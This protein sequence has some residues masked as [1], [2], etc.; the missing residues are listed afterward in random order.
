MRDFRTTLSV[1]AVGDAF[2]VV[3]IEQWRHDRPPAIATIVRNKVMADGPFACRADAEAALARL[4]V[5]AAAPPMTVPAP[6]TPAA[7]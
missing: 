1:E 3:R 5:P 6:A 7:D 2:A 4:Q